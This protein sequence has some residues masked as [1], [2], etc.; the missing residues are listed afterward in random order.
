MNEKINVSIIIVNYNSFN[1]LKLCLDSLNRFT[2]DISYEIIVV[3]NNSTEGSI[4]DFLTG[5][6]EIKLIKNKENE[7]FS[8]ANNKGAAIAC[9]KYL[10]FINNDVEFI[11]NTIKKVVEFHERSRDELLVGCKLLNKDLSIQ[12]SVT[13]FPSLLNILGANLFLYKIFPHS[14]VLNKNYLM[15]Q[16]IRDP[17]DFIEVDAMFGA[18]LSLSRD[19][20]IKLG[21]FDEDFYFYHE[22]TDLC[23]RFKKTIGKV[24]YYKSTSVIHYGGGTTQNYLWFH[25]KHRTL[26]LLYFMKKHFATS[27]FITGTFIHYFGLIIRS[28]LNFLIGA[29]TFNK[30]MIKKSFYLFRSLFIFPISK[31]AHYL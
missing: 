2:R 9:G 18:F 26:S 22:D 10:F 28:P 12:T 4:D 14:A 5:Y 17:N 8:K 11:Q 20:Y 31:S 7:G 13:P 6:K 24:I 21:G 29:L 23:F 16:V 30:H 19:S 27:G 1:L 3:D 15:K 25:Y